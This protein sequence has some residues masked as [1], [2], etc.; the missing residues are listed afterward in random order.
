MG[1]MMKQTHRA[2]PVAGLFALAL[3]LVLYLVGSIPGNAASPAT[4]SVHSEVGYQN[5]SVRI[6]LKGFAEREVVTLWQTFPDYR[7]LPLFDVTADETGRAYVDIPLEA[8]MPTG[9]HAISARGNTSERLAITRFNLT[10]PPVEEHTEVAIAVSSW[11]HTNTQGSIFAFKGEGYQEKEHVSLWI[12]RPDG[13]VL[14]Q[15]RA[16]A[17]GGT[18]TH[19][20]T[21]GPD[22]PAGTYRL[23]GFGQ[24]SKKTAIVAFSVDRAD[25]L[26]T[27]EQASLEVSP[28]Q[29]HQLNVLTLIG[30]GFEAG[31]RV[32]LWL[33]LPDGSSLTLYEGITLNG[34][35]RE[36]IY[37]PALIPEGGL[38]IGTH[39]ISAYGHTSNRRA[40]AS[41]MLLAGNGLEQ[42]TEAA[43]E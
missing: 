34:A 24:E 36:E 17:N 21:P 30:R 4:L 13:T 41:F 35:F 5:E 19:E 25:F 11:N 22:A 28:A 39:N 32:A 31:E 8:S 1:K 9:N 6:A 15:G 23:T 33:T 40:V 43:Q 14:D 18:F 10:A 26:S 37:L 16:R 27:A 38:P 20:F 7:V 42:E 3:F 29:I 2:A 12:T